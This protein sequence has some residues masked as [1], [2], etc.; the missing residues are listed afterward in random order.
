[1]TKPFV[2]FFLVP[3][4]GRQQSRRLELHERRNS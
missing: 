2:F 1:M 4:Y 3:L